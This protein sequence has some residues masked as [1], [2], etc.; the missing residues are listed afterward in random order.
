MN[1]K[2]FQS[3]IKDYYAKCGRHTLPWR[4]TCDPY[5][6]LVSEIMLQQ[7]QVSRVM[8]K[9]NE[10]LTLFPT[11]HDLAQASTATVLKTWQGLGYNRR[12]LNLKR[13]AETIVKNFGGKFPRTAE[14]LESLPGIGQSTRGAI[15]AFAFGIPTVFIETNIRAIYLHHFFPTQ[16]NVHDRDILPF[17]EKTLD[18]ENPRDWYYALMDYGVHLKQTL[19][20]PSRKSVHHTKQSSFKGSNR[21]VRSRILKFV[22]LK[23]RTRQEIVEHIGKTSYDVEKNIDD[24]VK[25]GFMKKPL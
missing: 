16:R 5:E 22:L 4:Q 6:I 19:P 3:I 17:I 7:T 8:T 23:K 25:E 1:T 10:F 20:N 13:A 11:A 2:K 14:E 18:T 24:L 15:M 9:Y 21:E 12:A